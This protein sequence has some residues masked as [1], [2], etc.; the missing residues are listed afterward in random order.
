MLQRLAGIEGFR[1]VVSVC[2]PVERLGYALPL[3][4]AGQSLGNASAFAQKYGSTRFPQTF[5]ELVE[6][7]GVYD[8]RWADHARPI[9]QGLRLIRELFDGRVL[10]VHKRQLRHEPNRP[11]Q[12]RGKARVDTDRFAR[13]VCCVKSDTLGLAVRQ[14]GRLGSGA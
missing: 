2:D 11:H 3:H 9:A 12:G 8:G 14:V 7:L 10:F 6:A 1:A 4:A 13:T 5:G